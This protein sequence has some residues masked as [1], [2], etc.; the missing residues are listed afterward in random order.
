MRE[1]A[2]GVEILGDPLP[3][4]DVL[5]EPSCSSREPCDAGVLFAEL[6]DVDSL[7][8]GR[9]PPAVGAVLEAFFKTVNEV[10][11]SH[12]G[13]AER[14]D[15]CAV[16]C[17]FGAPASSRRAAD[18]ALASGRDL[19]DRVVAELPD[20]A[21]GIG[22]SVGASVGGWIE[23]T[24]RFEPLVV[25]APV[26]EARRLCDL[27]GR[28]GPSVLVSERALARASPIEAEPW[29][30]ATPAGVTG[31]PSA[32]LSRTRPRNQSTGFDKSK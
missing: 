8:I 14:C 29:S 19:R 5:D 32:T 30:S 20:V 23:A 25:C 17:V 7:A 13:Y 12:G 2:G 1:V 27:A 3:F 26:T 10:A 16:L 24:R 9:S 4:G 18:A 15:L 22:I 21:F 28:G 6:A 11:D 31:F